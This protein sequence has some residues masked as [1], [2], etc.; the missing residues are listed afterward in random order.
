MN[1]MLLSSYEQTNCWFWFQ[2]CCIWCRCNQMH[3]RL[4]VMSDMLHSTSSRSNERQLMFELLHSIAIR[5]NA[6]WLLFEKIVKTASDVDVIRCTD[7]CFNVKK[8]AFNFE[9]SDALTK[10]FVI[11]D[12]CIWCW[13]IK[14][15]D[16][17]VWLSDCCIQSWN[18]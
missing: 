15:I 9:R 8:I 2:K 11:S 14:C 3:W 7:D 16:E 12:D 17:V 13:C 1:V 10:L 18:N 6:R 4:N 5:L